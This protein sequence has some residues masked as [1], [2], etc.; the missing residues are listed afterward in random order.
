MRIAF[1]S[2]PQ[3]YNILL[4]NYFKVFTLLNVNISEIV[5]SAEVISASAEVIL[6]LI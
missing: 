6:I 5:A 1:S 2:V 3:L 4:L